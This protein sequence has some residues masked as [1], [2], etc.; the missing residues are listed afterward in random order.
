MWTRPLLSIIQLFCAFRFF[1]GHATVDRNWLCWQIQFCGDTDGP[2]FFELARYP[3]TELGAL[4]DRPLLAP[5]IL[6]KEDIAEPPRHHA[7]SD[8]PRDRN[9]LP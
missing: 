4:L 2:S 3:V 7:I 8:V 1:R 6:K 5:I 9:S